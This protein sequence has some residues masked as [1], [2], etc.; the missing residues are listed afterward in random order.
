MTPQIQGGYRFPSPRGT[1]LA[2]RQ[3]CLWWWLLPDSSDPLLIHIPLGAE[4]KG[5][6][7]GLDRSGQIVMRAVHADD[8]GHESV[9]ARALRRLR[10]MNAGLAR[11]DPPP[12][13]F[14]NF[15][16][17]IPAFRPLMPFTGPTAAP[18]E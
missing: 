12:G 15:S 8:E 18:R 14:G 11:R 16:P 10:G 2:T 4:L 6:D 9:D 17:D 3:G 1:G 7:L 13:P 5:M